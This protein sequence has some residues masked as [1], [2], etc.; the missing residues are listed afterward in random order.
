MG[1][2]S[3]GGGAAMWLKSGGWGFSQVGVGWYGLML[4]GGGAKIWWVGL[5]SGR[6]ELV[7][8]G[9]REAYVR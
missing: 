2:K 7:K 6:Y 5:K 8:S 4:G 1:S 9:M 3:G